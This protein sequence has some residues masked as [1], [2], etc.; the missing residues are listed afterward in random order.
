MPS[1]MLSEVRAFLEQNEGIY[2]TKFGVSLGIA[3]G[4]NALIEGI[5]GRK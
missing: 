1:H 4:K 3:A 5:F 2:G